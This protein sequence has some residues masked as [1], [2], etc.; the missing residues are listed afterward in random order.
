MNTDN[1]YEYEKRSRVA[2]H[3]D[4]VTREEHV[5]LKTEQAG[6]SRVRL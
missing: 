4:V 1:K 2:H 3:I 5:E 6:T